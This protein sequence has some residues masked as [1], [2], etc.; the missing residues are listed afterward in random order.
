MQDK[1]QGH[2]GMI[3][4]SCTFDFHDIKHTLEAM[5]HSISGKPM[6]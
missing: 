3:S 1:S 5:K 2:V 4:C 6:F